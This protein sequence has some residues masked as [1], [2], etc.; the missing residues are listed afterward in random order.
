VQF[1]FVFNIKPVF[2]LS[3]LFDGDKS[4]WLFSKGRIHVVTTWRPSL[5]RYPQFYDVK[6]TQ[7]IEQGEPGGQVWNVRSAPSTMPPTGCSKGMTIFDA[8]PRSAR[9]RRL[10]SDG[11]EWRS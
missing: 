4:T 5:R 7:L 1:A 10:H 9:R 11:P 8:G 3:D 6:I 2:G